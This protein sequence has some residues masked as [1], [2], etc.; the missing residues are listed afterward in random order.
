MKKQNLKNFCVGLVLLALFVLWTLGVSFIDVKQIGPQNSSVGFA[1]LNSFVHSLT[2]TNM[3]LYTITDWAGLVPIAFAMGF[4]VLGLV[5]WIKRKNIL[6]VDYNILALGVFYIVVFGT[7]ILFEYIIINY[8]P[9]LIYGYLEASYPSSTTMLVLCVMPTVIMELN[10]RIKNKM[11]KKSL[12]FAII[13]FIVF[14]VSGR[15][16]SGVHW[17]SDIIGAVLLSAGLLKLYHA[18]RKP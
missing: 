17:F 13:A 8:R 12:C 5:Q 9:V 14:M 7:Y 16:I 6:N 18:V 4:G 11:L 2:G 15:L 1:S 10:V 3:L